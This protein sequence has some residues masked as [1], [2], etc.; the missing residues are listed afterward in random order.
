MAT[1]ST[2]QNNAK[3]LL[4][5]IAIVLAAKGATLLDTDIRTGIVL[6]GLSF[7]AVFGRGIYKKFLNGEDETGTNLPT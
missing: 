4:L 7:L 1:I 6:L 3:E 5:Y 2:L